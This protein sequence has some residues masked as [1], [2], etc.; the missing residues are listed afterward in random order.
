MWE[1][2]ETM[3]PIVC[4]LTCQILGI[5]GSQI[6]KTEK[7]F[8]FNEH[9]HEYCLQSKNILKNWFLW[10]KIDKNDPKVCRN[11]PSNLLE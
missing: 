11:S 10:T 7:T 1:K 5:V 9:I 6:H 3:F 2:Y 4:L 8:F